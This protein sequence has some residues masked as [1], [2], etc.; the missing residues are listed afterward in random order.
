MVIIQARM[1]SERLPGK[2]LRRLPNGRTVLEQIIERMRMV[3]G[4]KWLVVAIPETDAGGPLAGC[5]RA[6]GAEV[7]AGSETDVLDRF[8]RCQQQYGTEAVIR[9]TADDP[10]RDSQITGFLWQEFRRGH[11]DWLAST[12]LPDGVNGEVVRASALAKAWREAV[13]P[14]DRE[15]VT[16]FIWRQPERFRLA[17]V[18]YRRQYGNWRLTLDEEA[19]WQLVAEIDRHLHR[20][21]GCLY[22]IAAIHRFLTDNPEVAA[23]NAGV[24][25]NRGYRK[26]L[27]EDEKWRERHRTGG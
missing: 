19:D 27:E 24:E 10:F 20:R 26:S 9:V 15:H 2:V 12:G 21:W 5:A 23:L 8:Y 18:D 17:T 6:A 4:L 13:L 16:P 3:S 22:D 1:S 25:P 11:C 7:F 14:S